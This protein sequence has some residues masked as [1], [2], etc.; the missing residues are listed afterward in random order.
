MKKTTCA[1]VLVTV[2]CACALAQSAPK[3]DIS[4]IT[5][6][7]S[8]FPVS[9][10]KSGDTL[11][12]LYYGRDRYVIEPTTV[13]VDNFVDTQGQQVMRVN[14]K[15]NRQPVLLISGLDVKPGPVKTYFSG[16]RFLFPGESLSICPDAEPNPKTD[17]VLRAYGNAVAKGDQD[18]IHNYSMRLSRNNQSQTLDYY[19]PEAVERARGI[20]VLNVSNQTTRPDHVKDMKLP[21]LIW[22]GDLD[23]DEKVDL[24]TWWPCPGKSGGVYSLFLSSNAPEGKLAGKVSVGVRTYND[25]DQTK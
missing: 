5:P 9:N 12:G 11:P 7:C 21:V 8:L 3:T 1:L 16:G 22:A 2:F 17:Y 23:R 4:I 18:L 15:G 13:V 6:N 14:A 19:Q 25:I 20:A 24:F 10:I